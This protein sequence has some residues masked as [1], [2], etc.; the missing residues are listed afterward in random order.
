MASLLELAKQVRPI[1]E[2]AVMS[3]DDND[4]IIVKNF[5]QSWTPSTQYMTGDR[6]NFRNSLY[7]CLENHESQLGLDPSTASNL[8]IEMVAP[9]PSEIPEWQQ[10]ENDAGYGIGDKVRHGE[11]IWESTIN[12]NIWCPGSEGT[13]SL[14]IQIYD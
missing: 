7:K 5:F 2:K 4:A 10:P 1:I 13:E 12:N 8:W 6:V 9:T 11:K 14:W 3:L